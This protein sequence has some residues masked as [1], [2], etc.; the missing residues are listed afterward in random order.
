MVERREVHIDLGENVT[1]DWVGPDPLH[2]VTGISANASQWDSDPG[3]DAPNHQLGDTSQLTFNQPG[4]YDFQC[5]LHSLVRGDV[6]VSDDPGD[7]DS[8]PD[9]VPKSNVD[10]HQARM[11]DVASP[12]RSSAPTRTRLQY[13]LD[14]RGKLDVEYYRFDPEG[15][16]ALSRATRPRRQTSA[17]TGAGLA[18]ESPISSRNQGATW[19]SCGPPTRATTPRRRS[20]LKFRLRSRVLHRRGGRGP[21][22]PLGFRM[23]NIGPLEVAI[24][25]II[26]LIIFGPKRLPELGKS[27]GDGMREFKASISGENEDD[28]DAMI[29]DELPAQIEDGASRR[30]SRRRRRS[31]SARRR[32]PSQSAIG[33]DAERTTS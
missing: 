24:V 22:P 20:G 18:S 19:S 13:L 16:A 31:R 6:V 23:P 30:G 11:R 12:R 15:Q 7:P 32:A 17:T 9:P 21:S 28:D 33:R 10:L 29:D 2:S 8:E 4:T 26:A 25:A 3:T 14:E 5:K 27:L 1:W